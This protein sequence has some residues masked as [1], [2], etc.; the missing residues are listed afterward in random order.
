MAQS[1][2]QPAENGWLMLALIAALR[3]L[4]YSALKE[5][6]CQPKCSVASAAFSLNSSA[7]SPRRLKAAS[8][9]NGSW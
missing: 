9:L 8:Q 5:A 3:K 1:L 6:D 4:A 2:W 7:E